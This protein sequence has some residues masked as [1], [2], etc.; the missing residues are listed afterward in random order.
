MPDPPFAIR[1]QGEIVLII[2]RNVQPYGPWRGLRGASKLLCL[3]S[4]YVSDKR[5]MRAVPCTNEDKSS[6]IVQPRIVSWILN[7]IRPHR[8]FFAGPGWNI[9]TLGRAVL[10]A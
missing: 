5:D 3:P 4:R 8:I 10:L 9:N 7:P 6:G 2:G 1:F